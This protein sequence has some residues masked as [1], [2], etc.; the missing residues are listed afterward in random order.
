LEIGWLTVL[1]ILLV[2]MASLTFL[3]DIDEGPLG[4]VA[5]PAH[6]VAL[7]LGVAVFL[8]LTLGRGTD[9]ASDAVP[10]R[11]A[12]VSWGWL[13]AHIAL[14][15]GFGVFT[16]ELSDSEGTAIPDALVVAT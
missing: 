4:I 8:V 3:V 11:D 7:L 12:Q 10:D 14:L 9:P 1:A 6:S 2:E 16:I 15:V 13:A 5:N